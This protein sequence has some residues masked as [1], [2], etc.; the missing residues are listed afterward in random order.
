MG[1]FETIDGG[2]LPIDLERLTHHTAGDADV[3]RDVLKI[4]SD[5]TEV[6]TAALKSAPSPQ[7]WRDTAHT[8]KGAARGVG[9]VELGNL[10]E[11][12]ERV[13]AFGTADHDDLMARLEHAM[14]RARRY[15][16]QL[17]E[18]SPFVG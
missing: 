9:A 7:A 12:A 16:V 18:D 17:S 11:E 1:K 8:M 14:A 3:A 2:P 6:W 13:E 10:A 5:Q 15:A 4:F